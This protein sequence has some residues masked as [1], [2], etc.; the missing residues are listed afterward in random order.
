MWHLGLLHLVFI[1][2]R[3]RQS[4]AAQ[5]LRER[6]RRKGAVPELYSFTKFTQPCAVYLKMKFPKL[7][8][9]GYADIG[10][11]VS[12]CY[13]G[14]TNITVAK[15]EYNRVAKLRQ[16]QQLK[17]PKTETAIRYWND[18][19]NYEH[20][21]TVLLSQHQEYIDAWAEEHCTMAAQAELPLCY[22]GGRQEG[23]W[24]RSQTTTA[25][26]TTPTGHTGQATIQE[27]TV[28]V[29]RD[30]AGPFST[31]CPSKHNFGSCP[32]PS[33]ATPSRSTTHLVSSEVES[34]TTRQSPCCTGS[35]TTW[36]NRGYQ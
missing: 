12:F 34:T 28:D 33:L 4:A 21:S 17:L 9:A 7:N 35:P 1:F 3:T 27:A 16:L 8:S 19:Q 5:Q 11:D 31:F 14:S 30:K 6:L 24:S 32:T 20:F 25:S 26:R 29:S 23:S 10:K 36:S 2:H 22:K 18:S 13:I 15:R